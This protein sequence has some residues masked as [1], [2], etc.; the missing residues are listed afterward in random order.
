MA[1]QPFPDS[2]PLACPGDETPPDDWDETLGRA[3]D[4][5]ELD[6]AQAADPKLA[7]A[8]A[9]HQKLESL[10][11]LLRGDADPLSLRERA[12]V[13]VD[14]IGDDP[15]THLGRYVVVQ[16]PSAAAVQPSIGRQVRTAE[17]GYATILG[18]GAFGTVYL[19]HDPELNRE[20]AVKVSRAG[21]FASADA[22]D[23]I[24]A[25]ARHAA[26]LNHPGIVTIHDVGREGERLFIVMH[27]VPGRTLAELIGEGPVAPTRAAELLATVADALHYAHKLG[28]V[29]R[30]LKPANILLFTRRRAG[31]PAERRMMR[32]AGFKQSGGDSVSG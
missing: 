19:A 31:N 25:E 5:G 30:D 10:F 24:R 29:H 21:T 20:V 11:A 4:A 1:E 13:R 26:S 18:T 16:P 15:P 28:F 17:G 27:Y 32:T 9:A 22:F 23:K 8:F 14:C 7:G 6:P 12:R 2:P 3:I